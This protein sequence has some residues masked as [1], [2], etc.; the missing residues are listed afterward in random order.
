MEEQEIENL[1]RRIHALRH[2]FKARE[3]VRWSASERREIERRGESEADFFRI[4][5]ELS[6]LESMERYLRRNRFFPASYRFQL[7][8][9]ERELKYYLRG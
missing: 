9:W 2:A 4:V 1:L 3:R 6:R 5:W 8:N 7:R